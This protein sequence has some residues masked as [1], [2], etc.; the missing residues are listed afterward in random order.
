MANMLLNRSDSEQSYLKLAYEQ[1]QGGQFYG[2]QAPFLPKFV[3]EKADKEELENN[4][5]PNMEE[6]DMKNVSED[7]NVIG[8]HFVC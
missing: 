2:R 3:L 5:A 4:W 1:F 8:S 6:V 7:A